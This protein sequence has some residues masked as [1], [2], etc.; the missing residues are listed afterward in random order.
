MGAIEFGKPDIAQLANT[1]DVKGLIDALRHK[2]DW[3]VRRDAAIALGRIGDAKAIQALEHALVDEQNHV[4]AA[5]V[6]ALATMDGIDFDI[7]KYFLHD[8]S[9]LVRWEAARALGR[10]GDER[11]VE[12]LLEALQD[13]RTYVRRGAAWALGEIGDARAVKPLTTIAQ[14]EKD[15][16]REVAS[17][18]VARIES[19]STTQR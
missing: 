17:E 6:R 8:D 2:K 19:W 5:A 12:P 9:E 4:R 3:Q 13:E 16:I 7:L 11:A 1:G 15:R 14:N 18:A 10:I